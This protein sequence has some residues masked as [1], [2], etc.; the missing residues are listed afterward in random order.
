MNRTRIFAL[1]AVLIFPAVGLRPGT[2]SAASARPAPAPQPALQEQ[3]PA[4][5]V[6]SVL[7][8]EISAVEK[9]FVDAAGG[10]IQLIAAEFEDSGER[11]QGR[12]HVCWV[13]EARGDFE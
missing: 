9:E 3:Q 7:D 1:L 11:V 12:P 13:G 5:T 8:R 4:P 2:T 6:A 10:S